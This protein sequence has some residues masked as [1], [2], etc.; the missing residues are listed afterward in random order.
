MTYTYPHQLDIGQIK[1]KT[2]KICEEFNPRRQSVRNKKLTPGGIIGEIIG[3]STQT[4][5][6]Y[7]AA[8]GSSASRLMPATDMA[9]LVFARDFR[10]AMQ[11]LKPDAKANRLEIEQGIPAMPPY[12]RR[13]EN[14]KPKCFEVL[15]Q[16]GTHVI[17]VT[18]IGYAQLIA[19]THRGVV[20][21][22]SGKSIRLP[23][24][25]ELRS[26]FRRVWLSG[27]VGLDRLSP[28]FDACQYSLLDLLTENRYERRTPL[29]SAVLEAEALICQWEA[30]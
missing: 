27:Q 14:W 29:L 22:I 23:V 16:Y 13:P 21:D 15:D 28:I 8:I 24:E 25:V 20:R 30:A 11:V 6:Q 17:D 9:K 1:A 26:R 3:K 18:D 4:V 5:A 19:D 2:F 12:V 10:T 7:R